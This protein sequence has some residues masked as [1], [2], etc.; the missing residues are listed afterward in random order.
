MLRFIVYLVLAM[1]AASLL[2]RLDLLPGFFGDGEYR[3]F[4]PGFLLLTAA[5]AGAGYGVERLTNT[6][7]PAKPPEG[8]QS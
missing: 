7:C 2:Y 5:L 3:E 8:D 1:F 6:I 4:F